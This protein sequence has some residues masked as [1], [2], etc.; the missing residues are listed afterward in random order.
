MSRPAASGR[1]AGG[2]RVDQPAIQNSLDGQE[3]PPEGGPPSG[4]GRGAGDSLGAALLGS[5]QHTR[6]LHSLQPPS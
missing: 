1:Y 6:T 5:S 3:S 4:C 2:L